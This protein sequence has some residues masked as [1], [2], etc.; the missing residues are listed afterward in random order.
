[1]NKK[2]L[3]YHHD[4][5]HGWIEVDYVELEVLGIQDKITSYSYIN[6]DTVYLEEDCDAGLYYN[7]LQSLGVEV[8]IK[9]I[10]YESDSFIR[11]LPGYKAR[12]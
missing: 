11:D 6:R 3:I 8:E 12:D 9:D 7:K 4:P 5:A 1:M 10:Y 2:I